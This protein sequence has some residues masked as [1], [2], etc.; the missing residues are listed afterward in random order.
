MASAAVLGDNAPLLDTLDAGN[1][2]DDHQFTALAGTWSVVGTLLYER[3]GNSGDLR[4]ELRRAS[5]A[6][7]L[8][9]SD[10]VGNFYTHSAL[11]VIAIDGR[12]LNATDTFY[13]SQ[14]LNQQAPSYAVEFEGGPLTIF[15]SPFTDS[16]SIG[17]D[18]VVQ[19]YQIFLNRRDTIDVQLQV[20]ATYTYNYNLQLYL[21][22]ATT[23]TYYSA[24]A[25]ASPGPAVVSGGPVNSDQY[26]RYTAPSDG[27][28]LLVIGNTKELSDVPYS[29]TVV[30]NGSPLG[31]RAPVGG[32]VDTFNRYDDYA[33]SNPIDDWAFAAVRV[34]DPGYGKWITAELHSPTFDSNV[35]AS[36]APT[37]GSQRV[38]VVAVNGFDPDAVGT[39]LLAVRW[40]P[41]ALSKVPYTVEMDN[42]VPELFEA[43]APQ[44]VNMSSG[45]ILTGFTVFLNA[46]ETLELHAGVDPLFTYPYEIQLVAF[47]PGHSYY[48]GAGPAQAGPIVQAREGANAP[49]DLT[50]TAPVSGF[51]GIAVLS[52]I[53]ANA[54]P[55]DIT[56]T[57]QG[58]LLSPSQPRIGALGDANLQDQFSFTVSPSRWGVVAGRL[59]A[60]PGTY[61]QR[62]LANGLD[63]NPVAWDTVGDAPG[64]RPFGIE[65]VN[66]YA[67]ATATDFYVSVVRTA[68][69]PW[70]LLEY[71]SAPVT[72][73]PLNVTYTS[74]IPAGQFVEGFEIFLNAGDTA[75]FRLMAP[76]GYTYPYAF[77]M[78]AYSPAWRY[79]STSGTNAPGPLT[80]STGQ[81]DTEQDLSFAAPTSGYYLLVVANL[82]NLTATPF[83]LSVIVNGE[84]LG[85]GVTGEGDV[86]APNRENFYRFS[87]GAAT[88][89][90]AGA[91]ITAASSPT[92]ALV[93][94]LRGPTADSI[95]LASDRVRGLGGQGVIA[96]DGFALPTNT[97]YYLSES[98][99]LT[100]SASIG[101][102]IQVTSGFPALAPLSQVVSATLPSNSQLV[103]YTITLT[104]GQTLDLRLRRAEG[105]SYPFNLGLFVFAPGSGNASSSGEAGGAPISKSINGAST[106][107]D[108]IFTAL[109][110]GAHLIVV[111]NLDA[112]TE[113]NFT[114][115]LSLDGWPL[116]D[117][118][119]LAGDLSPYNRADQ[120]H[121]QTTTGTWNVA[122]LKWTEGNAVI[123]AGLHTLGLN[124]LPIATVDASSS[125]SVAVLP[126][127]A[128]AGASNTSTTFFLN[129]TL[130]PNVL[131]A[132][133]AY[134]VDLGSTSA[135]WANG[136]IG[137]TRSFNL[138]GTGFLALHSLE[139][140]QGDWIEVRMYVDPSYTKANDLNVELFAAPSA[141]EVL[142]ATPIAS[143]KNGPATDETL[144]LFAQA[145][146]LYLLVVENAG[147]LDTVPYQLAVVRHTL[148]GVAPT[149]VNVTVTADKNSIQVSWSPNQDND[150]QAY[151]AC[152]SVDPSVIGFC[153]EITKRDVTTWK[154]QDDP[155]IRPGQTYWVRV[156]VYDSEH[157][158]SYSDVVAVQTRPAEILD[159]P[160]LL[161]VVVISA[162]IVVA[163]VVVWWVSTHSAGAKPWRLRS[164]KA[165]GVVHEGQGPQGT[166]RRPKAPEHGAGAT[167]VPAA[168]PKSSQEAVDF[169]QRMMKGGR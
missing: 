117:D 96:I 134:V 166:P 22:G 116:L 57:I 49:K 56:V 158:L 126:F 18:G 43:D 113:V 169:M 129:V 101:Y 20:P 14:I 19:S 26:L 106:E 108:G 21:F 168:P 124:T 110:G 155:N 85:P 75:D 78:V 70:Y 104:K 38:G 29:L 32:S 159:D 48:A 103:G 163:V 149:K 10:T 4:C 141:P 95:D 143:S 154:F 111:A 123:R 130:A 74:S 135:L 7:A 107:Q 79:Y 80:A 120:Y 28:Y 147:D 42:R 105:F 92:D 152:Y 114:L 136:D 31:D 50:F 119:H 16:T 60:G 164:R 115:N 2:R 9:A 68:G 47:A 93:H 144:S 127:L 5:T 128:P 137:S 6:G 11:S 87:A 160:V 77:G 91:K 3:L 162:A 122:G 64:T 46:S 69:S 100:G 55:L 145:D 102:E 12:S 121:F 17:P 82:G 25:S 41:N 83:T 99:D 165:E 133:G 84:P 53:S 66:G 90:V 54:L 71:D 88:W 44:R 161:A 35:L 37:S 138:S 40:G 33:Y 72:I 139:L 86:T 1:P 23:S 8:L 150:F 153:E 51:Y 94:S 167:A 30:T 27:W 112:R 73:P 131:A 142:S 118:N 76:S 24:S 13:V 81:L 39:S 67:L 132:P 156:I 146:G 52:L 34:D 148:L 97:T 65:V 140:R 151:Q 62:L 59:Y 61:T 109:V 125:G 36:E 157:R 58:R 89:T 98:A 15:T 45:E 63:T